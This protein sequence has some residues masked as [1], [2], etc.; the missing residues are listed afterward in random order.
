[1]STDEPRPGTVADTSRRLERVEEQINA[2]GEQLNGLDKRM[3][4]MEQN[5]SHTGDLMKAEF[6]ALRAGQDAHGA[7]LEALNLQ[8]QTDRIQREMADKR[9]ITT[10]RMF[11]IAASMATIA[12]VVI[13]SILAIIK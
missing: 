11:A 4:L 10:A 12:G 5:Q 8:A 6:S 2:Q 1:M 9:Q 3:A 7:K 13:G